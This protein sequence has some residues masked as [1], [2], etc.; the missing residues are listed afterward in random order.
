MSRSQRRLNIDVVTPHSAVIGHAVAC[1]RT[2]LLQPHLSQAFSLF[3]C[4]I[5]L[6]TGCFG[7][8]TCYDAQHCQ[9]CFYVI[10]LVCPAAVSAYACQAG[11]AVASLPHTDTLS[12]CVCVCVC[13]CV[14]AYVRALLPLYLQ[15]QQDMTCFTLV[16]A[17]GATCTHRVSV[18]GRL[19]TQDFDVLRP[20]ILTASV[21]RLC[22]FH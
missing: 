13:V 1:I 20:Y 10:M 17:K 8:E 22:E 14:R 7:T 11:H 4:Q 15:C 21:R 9:L 18:C 16:G 3:L 12:V 6:T 2:W 5:A 19:A